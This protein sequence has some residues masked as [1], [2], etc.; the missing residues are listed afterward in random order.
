MHTR[1]VACVCERYGRLCTACARGRRPLFMRHVDGTRTHMVL[2][3]AINAHSYIDAHSYM[4]DRITDACVHGIRA[5]VCA[6]VRARVGACFCAPVSAPNRASP[7]RRRGPRAARR[8]GFL[9]CV[10]VQRE[11]RRMEHCACHRLVPGMRLFR[12]GGA[13]V[14]NALGRASMQ[15]GRLCA[16]APPMRARVRTR[17]GT[18]LRGATRV[19][20]AAPRRDSIRSNIHICRCIDIHHKDIY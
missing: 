19:G 10:G 2:L 8:A 20:M 9:L 14:P 18:R 4:E 12:P 15:R 16:A 7:F 17:G 6:H 1:V 13:G 5:H 3:D 11:H